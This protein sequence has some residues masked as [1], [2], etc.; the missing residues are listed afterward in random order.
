MEVPK[1][2]AARMDDILVSCPACKAG[3]LAAELFA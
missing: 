2:K 1:A 3:L